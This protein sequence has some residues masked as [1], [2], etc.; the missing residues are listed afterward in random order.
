MRPW[1]K[2]GANTQ[3]GYTIVSDVRQ[4]R[5]W[6]NQSSDF[7]S[8]LDSSGFAEDSLVLCIVTAVGI[9]NDNME[10]A[11]RK[12]FISHVLRRKLK[13]WIWHSAHTKA[14]HVPPAGRDRCPLPPSQD[15]RSAFLTPP[16]RTTAVGWIFIC[17]YHSLG[18]NFQRCTICGISTS[19]ILHCHAPYRNLLWGTSRPCCGDPIV[20]DTPSGMVPP[21]YAPNVVMYGLLS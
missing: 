18:C 17:I 21:Q 14:C 9:S 4:N 1:L 16:L 13:H 2:W 20:L 5:R 11:P 8:D 7:G 10:T 6:H 19:M 12:C 15:T 3:P